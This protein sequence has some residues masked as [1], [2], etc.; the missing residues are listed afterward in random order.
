M[1]AKDIS[2]TE[3]L[4][5]S[6]DTAS[7][8]NDT[9]VI[10]DSTLILNVIG[11]H[12]ERINKAPITPGNNKLH[13]IATEQAKKLREDI[14]N[15]HSN[16]KTII[17]FSPANS[18]HNPVTNTRNKNPFINSIWLQKTCSAL[19]NKTSSGPDGIPNIV[20]KNLDAKFIHLLTI[21]FNNIINNS[22]YPKNWKIAKVIPILK[23]DK[24][25]TIPSSYRPISLLSNLS[26]L[27]E[28]I[29][30][31]ALTKFCNKINI[32]PPQQFGF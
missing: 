18:A 20:L 28:T 23:K 22:Y 8:V 9:Y 16:R 19:N 32:I 25:P 31:T 13:K 12:Y 29:L 4:K 14:E 15:R 24:D 1:D 2:L 7:K 11:T 30:N 17:D 3:K 21:V 5:I 6:T 27:F 10:N 26:K